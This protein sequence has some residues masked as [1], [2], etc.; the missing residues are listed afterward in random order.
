MNHY[1]IVHV[2]YNHIR[3]IVKFSTEVSHLLVYNLYIHFS[4]LLFVHG[5]T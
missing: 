4:Q 3:E 2:I 5:G 1:W